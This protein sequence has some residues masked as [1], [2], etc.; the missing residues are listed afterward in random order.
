VRPPLAAG[1]RKLGGPRGGPSARPSDLR[2]LRPEGKGFSEITNARVSCKGVYAAW[3]V[4]RFV[5]EG[6]LPSRDVLRVASD[7][8]RF[9]WDVLHFSADVLCFTLHV[10]RFSLRVLR[11]LLHVLSSLLRGLCHCFRG[12]NGGRAL[13]GPAFSFALPASRRSL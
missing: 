5:A 9:R 12:E 3:D 11:L 10:L 1:G 4:Q 13:C 8:L 6:R 2:G 7:V